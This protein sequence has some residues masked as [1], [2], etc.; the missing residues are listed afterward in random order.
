MYGAVRS[1]AIMGQIFTY[2]TNFSGCR[3]DAE[4]NAGS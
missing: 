1:T 4:C 3:I 2:A